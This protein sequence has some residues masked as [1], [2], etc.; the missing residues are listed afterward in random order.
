MPP[1]TRIFVSSM[2]WFTVHGYAIAQDST[3]NQDSDKHLVNLDQTCVTSQYS[4]I[5]KK[6]RV[7]NVNNTPITITSDRAKSKINES[8]Y[9]DGDVIIKQGHRTLKADNA[10]L[11]EPENIIDAQGNVF[12]HDGEIS[13][14]GVTLQ[15]NLISDDTLLTDATYKMMCTPG[16]GQAEEVFKNGVTFYELKDGTYTTCPDEDNSW[17][18]SAGKIEKE[19]DDIFADLYHARFEVLDVPIFYLPY[20]RIPA[21]DGR[22][23]GFLYPS[24]GWN[25]SDGIELET[26]F[27]WN[28]HPQVD[29][30]ITPT[31]MSNRGLFMSLEPRY[32]TNAGSGTMA[33]EY[34]G[35]DSLYPSFNKSWGVNWRHIGI[36]DHWKYNVD[37]SQVSDITYFNRHTDS[38][39]GNRED[40]TLLQTTELSFRETN[41]NTALIVRNFQAL[42]ENVS[43][44]KLLPQLSFN[45]YQPEIAYGV[46]FSMPTQLSKF[47]TD[48][49]R[50]PDALRLS[51]EPTFTL[52]YNLPWLN[53]AAQAKL[54]YT[55]YSQSNIEQTRGFDGE[56]LE[57]NATRVIPMTKVHAIVTL[58]RSGSIL[59]NAYTQTLE[60]QLQYLYIKDVDQSEIYN[61]VNYAGGGYDTAR[62]QT[63]Y[64][65][66]FRTNQ[67]S[68]IDYINPAN[69]FTV[70]AAT[71]FFDDGYKERFN[72]AF[73]QIYYL[74]KQDTHEQGKEPPI[75]YSAWAIE[76]E[77]NFNDQIFLSG[78]LEYD[79]NINDLQFGNATLEYR[80]NGFFAQTNYRYVSKNYIASTI[81]ANNLD[82]ITEDG[83]SQFGFVTG[84]PITNKINVN[85]QY[86]YD[87]TQDIMLENQVG[88]TYSSSCWVMGFSYN[89]YLLARSNIHN[90]PKYDNNFTFSFSLLG[91][92]ANAGFGYST[93]SG[94]ALGYR[95][96]F[97]LK[98]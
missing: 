13:I 4:C 98:N 75:N 81:G 2:I 27:Y 39:I 89:E 48:D 18:F 22:L 97:G 1:N 95:N 63:D 85:A 14:K 56:K 7:K 70:G 49:T 62:L 33:F 86:F 29:M 3:I 32:L 88:M 74:N 9:Y 77:L 65:G 82:L 61:P 46:D 5:S 17:R 87:L 43:V 52:P 73:G 69:Q 64:Y 78:S 80:K 53:A 90:L 28:I 40:N 84:F 19:R 34:M 57:A 31:Y 38:R 6:D 37:Y 42:S 59:E 94:N 72:V 92:G 83:I 68:S 23:T 71:R 60:P 93:D 20:L 66:L 76:S 96:P 67:Y 79:S 58:E 45:L 21:E 15:T 35:E 12:F 16:R 11:K 8:S 44:Y 50:K 51:F 54:F 41:W 24:I 36:M 10:T 25:D 91:L 26:P 30:L 55:H 47:V